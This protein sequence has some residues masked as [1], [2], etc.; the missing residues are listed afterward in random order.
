[1]P[2]AVN[3]PVAVSTKKQAML[4]CPLFGAYRN[5]PDLV[6]WICEQVFRSVKPSGGKVVM[7]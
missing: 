6:I 7:V 2:L 1:M 5:L 3:S 4:L